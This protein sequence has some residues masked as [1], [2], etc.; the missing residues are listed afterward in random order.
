MQQAHYLALQGAFAWK[1]RGDLESKTGW[2]V[3]GLYAVD[4]AYRLIADQGPR[5]ATRLEQIARALGDRLTVARRS[6]R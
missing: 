4:A 2:G 5:L 6:R 1:L 3:A